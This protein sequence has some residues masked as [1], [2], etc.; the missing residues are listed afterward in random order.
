MFRYLLTAAAAVAMANGMQ[1]AVIYAGN[2]ATINPDL[3]VSTGASMY[4]GALYGGDQ[5]WAEVAF[6][7]PDLGA[8]AAPFTTG[9]L[10][11]TVNAS[12]GNNSWGD[13]VSN[14]TILT[15][16]GVPILRD[17]STIPGS[18]LGAEG[19][20]TGPTFHYT[21]HTDL[22]AYSSGD[23]SGL[24]NQAYAN[25]AGIGKYVFFQVPSG[26]GQ[27]WQGFDLAG[28]TDGTV[29]DRPQIAYTAV[30]V[31]EPAVL[32]LV[33]LASAAL[34]IRRRRA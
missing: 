13:K 2:S 27:W 6:Q 20:Y 5:Y 32:G 10:T 14:T 25:G 17:T 9:T 30:A 23:L 7:L 34:M 29:A 26:Y 18:D 16:G 28:A 24:L 22:G 8:Q 11:L 1:A 31:P 21:D 19:T 3:S 4:V 33:A 15:S 12:Q